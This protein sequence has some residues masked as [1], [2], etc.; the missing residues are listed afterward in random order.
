MLQST[1]EIPAA[2]P[3]PSAIE[4][5]SFP[6]N[7]SDA[8]TRTSPTALT[9]RVRVRVCGS[10]VLYAL[11][12]MGGHWRSTLTWQTLV[13]AIVCAFVMRFFHQGP[14]HSGDVGLYQL[15]IHDGFKPSYAILEVR[16]ISIKWV[17]D[18]S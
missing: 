11:E 9:V 8:E 17:A 3:A 15:W 1:C 5:P 4:G 14:G 18:L 2:T 7:K 13:A 12:Q 16:L 6:V 10:G